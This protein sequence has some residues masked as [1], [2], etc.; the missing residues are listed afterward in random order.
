MIQTCQVKRREQGYILIWVLFF[1]GLFYLLALS[2]INESSLE[3]LI[4]LNHHRDVQAFAMADGGALLGAEQIY[5]ILA[6]DYKHEQELPEQ[7]VLDQQEWAFHEGGKEIRFTLE[8]PRRISQADGEGC[9]QFISRGECASAQK[10]ILVDVKVKYVD[11][12]IFQY[13]ADGT[14]VLLFDYRDFIYPAEVAA[15]KIVTA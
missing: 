2:F 10:K 13:A 7:L 11:Y 9:F 14:T 5:K 12:F 15:I 3:A 4:S 1:F 6:R 8:N